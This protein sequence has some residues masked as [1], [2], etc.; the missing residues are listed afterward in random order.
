MDIFEYQKNRKD[1]YLPFSF[2]N[3]SNQAGSILDIKIC[4]Y[5]IDAPN[6]QFFPWNEIWQKIPESI[7][8]KG[9]QKLFNRPLS[10]THTL[11]LL[12]NTVDYKY[13]NFF[14][15]ESDFGLN[16][17]KYVIEVSILTNYS[18]DWISKKYSFN[19]F[20]N[21]KQQVILTQLN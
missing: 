13:I 1:I 15:I 12:G 14:P 5:P 16:K 21:N 17:G 7:D 18:N 20:S 19:Y 8:S 10:Q 6:K 3:T 2:V 11:T 4:L 9:T